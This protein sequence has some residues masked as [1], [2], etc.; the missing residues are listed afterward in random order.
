MFDLVWSRVGSPWRVISSQKFAIVS[1]VLRVYWVLIAG[2]AAL[3]Q[4]SLPNVR[5]WTVKRIIVAMLEG[6]VWVKI[7]PSI[8]PIVCIRNIA[9]L[10][11]QVANSATGRRPRLCD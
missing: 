9:R 11:N 5:C 8:D 3:L 2:V 1:I 10:R 7:E 6:A 4:I